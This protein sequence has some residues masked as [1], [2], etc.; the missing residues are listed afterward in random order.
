MR[1][2]EEALR[3]DELAGALD[4]QAEAMQGLREGLRNLGE[5]LAQQEGEPGRQ[6]EA[7]GKADQDGRDPLGRQ[8][9]ARGN[10]GTDRQ[11]LQGEDVYRRAQKLLDEIRRRT[12]EKQRPK[13]ERDYLRRLLDQF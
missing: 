2:A 11:L 3:R 7:V 13:V 5:A 10:V 1:R 12:G 8:S 6:G 4:G 9:G